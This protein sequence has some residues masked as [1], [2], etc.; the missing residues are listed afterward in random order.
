[1]QTCGVDL[2]R[3]FL[4][5]GMRKMDDLDKSL[6]HKIEEMTKT[7]QDLKMLTK[8]Q[9]FLEK[10]IRDKTL[11]FSNDSSFVEYIDDLYDRGLF[12]KDGSVIPP[13]DRTYKFELNELIDAKNEVD[14][15]EQDALRNQ[16]KITIELPPAFKLI[17]QLLEIIKEANKKSEEE[18]E[19][20]I[21][22]SGS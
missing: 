16:Q 17:E 15:K 13:K 14:L 18:K 6:R 20:A 4:D 21:R 9:S 3:Q 2:G 11:D 7:A 10:A 12:S 1:M 19:A 5:V 8:A 22:H